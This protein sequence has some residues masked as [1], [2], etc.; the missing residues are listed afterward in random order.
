M[1]AFFAKR[2]GFH[3]TGIALVYVPAKTVYYLTGVSEPDVKILQVDGRAEWPIVG[4]RPVDLTC[5][6]LIFR[7]PKGLRGGQSGSSRID[8]A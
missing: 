3:V 5:R 1:V 4:F 2:D 8:I 6:Q 7:D